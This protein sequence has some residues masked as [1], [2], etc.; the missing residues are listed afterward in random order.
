MK[1]MSIKIVFD[2]KTTSPDL[3]PGWGFACVVRYDG[4]MIL[5]DTG[6]NG[7][8]L[9]ENMSKLAI[10]P[11]EIE[12]IVLSHAHW[13][14]TS[15]LGHI[16]ALNNHVTVYLPRSFPAPFK[17]DIT[18]TGANLIELSEDKELF[19]GIFSTGEM[20]GVIEEQS[21][22]FTSS[23]GTVVITG[24]AHPSI[25]EIIR[26][27]KEI[28]SDRIYLALGGFHFPK[29]AVIMRFQELGV[30]KAAPCHCSG[31]DA[32]DFFRQAY[33]DDFIEI[34]VG[35]EITIG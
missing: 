21:L 34:G 19:E 26:K 3:T 29:P 20:K 16:L 4:K 5:F 28:T 33:Q 6:A 14:H 30:E 17:A 18:D 7:A 31:D 25:V 35:K 15:G 12:V 10:N 22:A 24:C 11:K 8:I 27:S 32:L 23:K 1:Q 2:N 13:D 9:L